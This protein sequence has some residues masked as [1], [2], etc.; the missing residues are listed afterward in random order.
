MVFGGDLS[1]KKEVTIARF[2]PKSKEDVLAAST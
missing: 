2:L 1:F